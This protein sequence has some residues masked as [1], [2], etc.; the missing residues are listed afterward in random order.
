MNLI[1][2]LHALIL[3][4]KAMVSELLLALSVKIAAS[5]AFISIEGTTF[6]LLK[7]NT[8]SCNLFIPTLNG[9]IPQ[10]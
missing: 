6:P 7:P 10:L 5:N 3:L 9:R 2:Y 8:R 1:K 4:S